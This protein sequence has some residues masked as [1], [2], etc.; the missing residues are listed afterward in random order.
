[1]M[2][3][4]PTKK[5]MKEYEEYFKIEADKFRLTA[6]DL[7][8]LLDLFF[9]VDIPP[10]IDMYFRKT[11][12]MKNMDKWFYDFQDRIEEVVLDYDKKKS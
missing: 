7:H 6:E 12:K 4:K 10:E 2:K 5:G 3:M 11:L 1:M 9:M 8:N